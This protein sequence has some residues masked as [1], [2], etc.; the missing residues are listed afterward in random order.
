MTAATVRWKRKAKVAGTVEV[1]K[2][3]RFTPNRNSYHQ[4]I[5]KG[6]L[7]TLLSVYKYQ[8]WQ[9][10]KHIPE[11]WTYW[12]K[13]MNANGYSRKDHI[14]TL[15]KELLLDK[16]DYRCKRTHPN[17]KSKQW[18]KSETQESKRELLSWTLF[19]SP[20]NVSYFSFGSIAC[21]RINRL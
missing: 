11:S 15:N 17:Q 3:F 1:G 5:N 7:D 12:C 19:W 2:F 4:Q 14:H 8:W 21:I 9:I 16:S 18:Q 20:E 6:K 13:Y 10:E